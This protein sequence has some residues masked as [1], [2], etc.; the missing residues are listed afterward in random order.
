ML[1]GWAKNKNKKRVYEGVYVQER[2][3]KH[4]NAP[5]IKTLTEQ[6]SERK[7]LGNFCFPLYFPNILKCRHYFN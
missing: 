4:G 5:T 2:E 7:V 3:R 1:C 6:F